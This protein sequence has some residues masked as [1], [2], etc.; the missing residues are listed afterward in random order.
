MVYWFSR[1]QTRQLYRTS[2][3]RMRAL[4]QRDSQACGARERKKG[5]EAVAWMVV[6]AVAA[7]LAAS[8]PAALAGEPGTLVVTG[9]AEVKA[10]PDMAVFR[11]GV[12]TRAETLEEARAANAAAMNRVQERLLASGAEP[13]DLR[14][15]GFSVQPEWHYN[16]EDGTRTLVGYRVSHTLVVTVTR[17]DQLGAL[18]DAAMEEGANRVSGPTFGV[19]DPE[20]L[21]LEALREAVRRAK[22]KA[23]ALAEAAGTSLAGVA[24]IRESVVTPYAGGIRLATAA[25]DAAERA[26]TS[27]APGEVTVSATVTIV[28]AIDGG[29]GAE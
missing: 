5:L 28:Y 25:V 15:E 27:I 16:E 19:R 7:V 6:A 17:L 1:G 2:R 18:L 12:D 23:E 26:G 9:Q 24:E 13:R 14:T 11:V 8:A 22:R 3:R 10:E 20:A 29:P 21:E 4:T